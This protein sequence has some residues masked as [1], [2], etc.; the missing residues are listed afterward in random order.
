MVDG[1]NTSDDLLLNEHPDLSQVNEG[2]SEAT[3]GKCYEVS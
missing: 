3:S 2:P 1:E